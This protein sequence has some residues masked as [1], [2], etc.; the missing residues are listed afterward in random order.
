M[1]L[2]PGPLCRISSKDVLH[3]GN[4]LLE[5][6]SNDLLAAFVY[7]ASGLVVP[8]WAA[9]V[10]VAHDLIPARA[11]IRVISFLGQIVVEGVLQEVAPEGIEHGRGRR[12]RPILE[13]PILEEVL[14]SCLLVRKL[15]ELQKERDV[16][17]SV[18]V[19]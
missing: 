3:L 4:A 9:V 1:Q 18:R 16:C 19:E 13:V 14:G 2:A 5:G 11:A 17:G 12:V 8:P 6:F 7:V 15:I 10:Q